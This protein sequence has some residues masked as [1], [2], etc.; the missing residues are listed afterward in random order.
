M[1]APLLLWKGTM[2]PASASVV[3]HDHWEPFSGPIG[4]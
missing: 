3:Y 1:K 2:D 4:Q